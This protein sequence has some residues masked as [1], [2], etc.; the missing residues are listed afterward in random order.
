LSISYSIGQA[1][2]Q[3]GLNSRQLKFL[4]D[5]YQIKISR[6]ETNSRVYSQKDIDILKLAEELRVEGKSRSEI[7]SVLAEVVREER[8]EFFSADNPVFGISSAVDDPVYESIA[9][10]PADAFTPVI[11]IFSQTDDCE[12]TGSHIFLSEKDD[13]DPI[14]TYSASID[15]TEEPTL[16]FGDDEVDSLP[17]ESG[18][19]LVEIFTPEQVF[20]D[21]DA[22]KKDYAETESRIFFTEITNVEKAKRKLSN[23]TSSEKE[24]ELV[25]RNA[26]LAALYTIIAQLRDEVNELKL[27][28]SP[29][30]SEELIEENARLKAKIKEKTYELVDVRD[31]LGQLEARH[32]RKGF[33]KF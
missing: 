24:E 9:Q 19:K 26:D 17:E 27:H 22:A 7:R 30:G 10:Q 6:N 33:F 15:T 21:P 16:D 31:K 29:K 4:E 25:V 18:Q 5:Q 8:I 3:I 1:S 14:E 28:S 12:D 13:A 20:L 23:T 32:S 2:R 11:A